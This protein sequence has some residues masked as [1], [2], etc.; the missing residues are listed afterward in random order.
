MMLDIW[1][2]RKRVLGAYAEMYPEAA[3][4]R[5]R[6]LHQFQG[7][8]FIIKGKSIKMRIRKRANNEMMK[9]STR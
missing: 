5:V 9:Q 1:L 8:S 7:Q 6:S 4:A 2:N 3:I